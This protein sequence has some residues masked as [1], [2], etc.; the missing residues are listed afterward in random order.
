MAGFV[1]SFVRELGRPISAPAL[2]RPL[3]I[4]R[5][6][7]QALAIDSRFGT[8]MADQD[9]RMLSCNGRALARFAD[10]DGIEVVAEKD[11]GNSGH[12]SI[13]A[14]FGPLM[15]IKIGDTDDDVQASTVAS[16]LW[17]AVALASKKVPGPLP[18]VPDA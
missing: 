2:R 5:D 7:D 13:W 3:R 6:D 8:F 9:S 10:I 12:W 4:A 17:A 16:K 1:S 15:G 18:Y 11:N 14:R